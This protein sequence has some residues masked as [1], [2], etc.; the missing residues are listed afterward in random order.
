MK[1]GRV[2]ILINEHHSAFAAGLDNMRDRVNPSIED[3]LLVNCFLIFS[4][5]C[6]SELLI[7]CLGF[8]CLADYHN[9]LWADR[10]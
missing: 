5:A 8:I 6:V 2:D 7:R 1:V 4:M 9:Q 10:K 3:F